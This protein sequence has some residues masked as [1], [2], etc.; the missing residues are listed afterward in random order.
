MRQQRQL[1]IVCARD[2]AG[3]LVLRITRGVHLNGGTV[4]AELEIESIEAFPRARSE[5]SQ[6]VVEMIIVQ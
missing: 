6:D 3:G 4:S 1:E 5:M 2:I